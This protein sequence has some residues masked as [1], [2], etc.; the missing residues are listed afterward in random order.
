MYCNFPIPHAGWGQIPGAAVRIA[1]DIHDTPWVVNSAGTIYHWIGGSSW[2]AYPGGATDIAVGR[3]PTPSVWVIG[4]DPPSPGG[5]H[6]IY[7]WNGSSWDRIPGAAVHIS[8]DNSGVPWVVN[9]AGTIYKYLGSGSWQA[10]PGGATDIAVEGYPTDQDQVW[11]IG[12][13]PP[14]PGGD[15]SIYHWNGSSWDRI[16]GAAVDIAV[17]SAG[18][19]WVIN[20]AGTLYI[21]TESGWQAYA[22]NATDV[23]VLGGDAYV[24]GNM[25]TGTSC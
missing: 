7:H 11:V 13:D 25:P 24:L 20:S 10:Y 14:S 22:G 21:L 6:S 1:V 18:R 23:A 9:S 5:D 2:Q 16:P 8:V 12:N 15:H 4:N 3:T 17:D 19:P